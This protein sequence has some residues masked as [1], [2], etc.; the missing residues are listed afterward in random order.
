M[1]VRPTASAP[2]LEPSF[3]QTDGFMYA[4]LG[5]DRAQELI[6]QITRRYENGGGG[7]A[8][9]LQL[10]PGG[11]PMSMGSNATFVPP[12]SGGAPPSECFS[13][14]KFRC[15][16]WLTCVCCSAFRGRTDGRNDGRRR[17]RWTSSRHG[18]TPRHGWTSRDGRT[19][20]RT[21][22]AIRAAAVW[23]SRRTPW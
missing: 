7:Q 3:G 21:A 5:S 18:W 11:L 14:S 10:G 20:W 4:D 22:N 17:I 2:W 9:I 16:W 19:S 13:L 6:D 23:R 8:R 12:P 15:R 1:P